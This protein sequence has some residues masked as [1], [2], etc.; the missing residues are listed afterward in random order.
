M[1]IDATSTKSLLVNMPSY[2]VFNPFVPLM[3]IKW[4][5]IKGQLKNSHEK[6][7]KISCFWQ[8]R[9]GPIPW[10]IISAGSHLTIVRVQALL[11]LQTISNQELLIFLTTELL[12]SV[13]APVILK[14][15]LSGDFYFC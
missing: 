15:L 7:E 3:H 13:P 4:E 14:H 11:S 5:N 8:Q 2:Q 6:P 1:F 12:S 9:S 10:A